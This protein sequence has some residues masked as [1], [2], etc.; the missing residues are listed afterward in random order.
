[1][2]KIVAIL[3]TLD[4]KGTEYK[5]LKDQIESSSL[6]TFVIDAGVFGN[7]DFL[8]DISAN[9]IAEAAGTNIE[10]LRKADRGKSVELHSR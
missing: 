1:M 7:P 3:G 10:K 4:T 5:F 9:V 8:P 6:E 2:N